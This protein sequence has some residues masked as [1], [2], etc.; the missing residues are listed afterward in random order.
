M[1]GLPAFVYMVMMFRMQM[2]R[3]SPM[4]L[5]KN[6]RFVKAGLATAYMKGKSYLS[7]DRSQWVCRINCTDDFSGIPRNA[8]QYVDMSEF[9]RRL[10]E[11][12]YDKDE[13]EKL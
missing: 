12:I 4:M 7:W 11:N 2:I 10:N 13:F 1:K 6:S 5:V 8:Q 9:T 3:P